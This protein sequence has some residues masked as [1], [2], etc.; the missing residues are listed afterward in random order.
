[1][2]EVW[3][4]V[5]RDGV[6]WLQAC[7]YVEAMMPT[8]KSFR[9]KAKTNWTSARRGTLAAVGRPNILGGKAHTQMS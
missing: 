6:G 1:M 2:G 4:R 9:S 7:V 8:Y 3:G 5:R